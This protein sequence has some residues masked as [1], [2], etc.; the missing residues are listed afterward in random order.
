MGLTIE[1]DRLVD[2]TVIIKGTSQAGSDDADIAF[3]VKTLNIN[4]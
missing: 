1:L 2:G 3:D 4:V